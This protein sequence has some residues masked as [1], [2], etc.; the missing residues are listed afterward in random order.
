MVGKP[1]FLFLALNFSKAEFGCK[2]I[3][4]LD[5]PF[6]TVEQKA[7]HAIAWM[8]L[9]SPMLENALVLLEAPCQVKTALNNSPR[10][11]VSSE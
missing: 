1:P 11:S 9:W 8:W 7:R 4:R 3:Q 5:L 6:K 10:A 2:T